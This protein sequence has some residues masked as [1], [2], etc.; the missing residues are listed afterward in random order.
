MEVIYGNDPTDFFCVDNLVLLKKLLGCEGKK[1]IAILLDS[2]NIF[3]AGYNS[4][5]TII[6]YDEIN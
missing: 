5:K 1:G 6:S 4:H 3:R 2:N